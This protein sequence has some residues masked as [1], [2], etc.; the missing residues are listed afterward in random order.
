[1]KATHL[2]PRLRR[3]CKQ[4]KDPFESGNYCDVLSED[5]ELAISSLLLEGAKTNIRNVDERIK[6]I[7]LYGMEY[8]YLLDD[9]NNGSEYLEQSRIIARKQ[10]ASFYQ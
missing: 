1:M 3:P 9:S 5:I 6:L 7:V 8:D 4:I 2:Q 10:Y